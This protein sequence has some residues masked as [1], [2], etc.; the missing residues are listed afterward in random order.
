MPRPMPLLAA[1]VSTVLTGPILL[2]RSPPHDAPS[3]AALAREKEAE[4]SGDAKGDAESATKAE[5]A[6]RTGTGAEVG[7][8]V[9]TA[10][11][12]QAAE[13]TSGPEGTPAA[14]PPPPDEA[15][16]PATPAPDL[17]PTEPPPDPGPLPSPEPIPDPGPDLPPPPPA[18]VPPPPATDP[19]PAPPTEDP[20]IDL[21]EENPPLS[22]PS[23]SDTPMDVPQIDLPP[24][25]APGMPT[26]VLAPAGM[27]LDRLQ[28]Y[29]EALLTLR[30]LS[31][32]RDAAAG[33]LAAL[34]G[35]SPAELARRYPP[36]GPDHDAEALRHDLQRLEGAGAHYIRL[37]RLT[38]DERARV[39]PPESPAQDYDR[40]AYAAAQRRALMQ[41]RDHDTLSTLSPERRAALY[42]APAPRGH[43]RA[44]QDRD[45]RAVRAR[46][47]AAESA[48]AGATAK[49]EQLRLTLTGGR[50][51]TA[52]EAEW[53]AG[54][55]DG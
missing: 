39:F 12:G 47:A 14:P 11:A 50:A 38:D 41:A 23:P 4:E 27:G 19:P 1:T 18:E 40:A 21:P 43:D 35:L 49:A 15:P 20:G 8:E 34:E 44:A 33:D 10:R 9:R 7:R 25:P 48:V 51:L 52:T 54:Y 55:L 46:L 6:A 13:Q 16:D 5:A 32:T 22:D 53:L 17:P 29:A 3:G 24:G 31:T 26:M 2:D 37:L 30:R 42:P 28:P 36:H 45:L